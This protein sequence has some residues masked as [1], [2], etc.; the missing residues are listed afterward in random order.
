MLLSPANALEKDVR[1]L[2]GLLGFSCDEVRYIFNK[3]Y[4]F[5]YMLDQ[6][7]K[8][9]MDEATLKRLHT[10]IVELQRPDAAEIVEKVVLG[11][12]LFIA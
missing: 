9:N 8:R 7:I 6:W 2:S 3:Q 5:V 1:M 4:P 10:A 12:I 11:R